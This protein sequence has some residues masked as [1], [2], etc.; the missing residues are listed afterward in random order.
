[1]SFGKRRPKLS[2]AQL[3]PSNPIALQQ[4][5]LA[6]QRDRLARLAVVALADPG[7]RRDRPRLG[8]V[9]H[10]P[11]R[12][13]A[14][15]RDPRQRRPSSSG[16]TRSGPTPNARPRP[17]RSRRRWSTTRR[18]S[19]TWPSGSTTWSTPSP[20]RRPSTP[21][22]RPSGPAGSSTPGRLRRHPRGAATPPSGARTCT[23]GSAKAFEPLIR[24]GVLGPDI[25]PRHEEASRTLAVRLAGQPPERGPPRP[26]RPGRCPSGSTSPTGRSARSSSPPSTPRARPGPLRPDRRP[27]RR[28]AHARLRGAVHQQAPRA[29]PQLPSPTST[30]PTARASCWSSRA[31]R[32]ARS[33]SSCSARSTRSPT[34]SS[35]WATGSGGPARSSSWSAAM[36]ALIGYYIHR[37][38]P[39]IAGDLRRIASICALSVVALGA[40][41]APG[42]PALGRRAGPGG[43]RRDDPG[44]RLQPPLRPDGHLR[45]EPADQPWRWARG[46]ATS[47]S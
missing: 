21:S 11:A 5:R 3:R 12:P 43:D 1:M 32:S 33:S 9:L 37:H 41:P 16:G 26:P 46:S 29:G 24:D 20:R 40:G 30:R 8:A 19:A 18:R 42:D 7:D 15:P 28:H 13:A 34:P 38:E 6:R 17:T 14:R 31:R 47:S 2:R 39:L 10:L 44:D 27:A 45:P 36:F 22:P 4:G 25:L 23:G 35:R